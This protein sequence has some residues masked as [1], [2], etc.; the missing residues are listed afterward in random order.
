MN[1]LTQTQ[2]D[3]KQAYLDRQ[4]NQMLA[5]YQNADRSERNAVIRQ[6]DSFLETLPNDA[7]I[8]WLK[9]REKL[10][11]LNEMKM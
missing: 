5:T 1:N 3:A 6:I 8:F 4:A 11:R 9:F 2:Q 10:E 7:K